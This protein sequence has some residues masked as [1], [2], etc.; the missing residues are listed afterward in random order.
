MWQGSLKLHLNPLVRRLHHHSV[1]PWSLKRG[2]AQVWP[3]HCN[4]QHLQTGL[5]LH[6]CSQMLSLLLQCGGVHA[7]CP[8]SAALLLQQNGLWGFVHLK[9]TPCL[10]KLSFYNTVFTEE[11]LESCLKLERQAASL[12]HPSHFL[13]PS[14]PVGHNN[15]SSWAQ[16]LQVLSVSLSFTFPE[17]YFFFQILNA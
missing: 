9:T 10:E 15:S 7:D 4:S 5:L 16:L 12:L 1:W 2:G 3:Q 17:R 14:V 13:L 6:L 11:L 8:H